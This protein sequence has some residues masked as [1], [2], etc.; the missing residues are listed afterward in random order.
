ML[1]LIIK[2]PRTAD[3]NLLMTAALALAQHKVNHKYFFGLNPRDGYQD[4]RDICREALEPSVALV[5]NNYDLENREYEVGG[6]MVDVHFMETLNELR[7]IIPFD[8]YFEQRG[9]YDPH[10]SDCCDGEIYDP[11]VLSLFNAG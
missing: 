6:E 8:M 7:A 2:L 4:Y 3:A 9:I 10:E 5:T 1:K 11:A